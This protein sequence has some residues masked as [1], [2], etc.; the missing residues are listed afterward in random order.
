VTHQGNANA[1]E[2]C[3]HSFER[4]DQCQEVIIYILKDLIQV[5]FICYATTFLARLQSRAVFNKILG[6]QSGRT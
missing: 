5:Q 1:N 6:G 4:F 3:L 2:T